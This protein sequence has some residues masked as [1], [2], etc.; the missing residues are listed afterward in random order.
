MF[1][2]SSGSAYERCSNIL[3]STLA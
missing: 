2:V 3:I 1:E